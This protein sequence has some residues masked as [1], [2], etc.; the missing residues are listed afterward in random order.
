MSV[1]DLT[2]GKMICLSA[3]SVINGITTSA[4]ASLGLNRM[5]KNWF[6]IV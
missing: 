1:G 3:K 2:M 5:L 4:L 6:F